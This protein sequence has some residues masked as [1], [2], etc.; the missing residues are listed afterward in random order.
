MVG[1]KKDTPSLGWAAKFERNRLVV[2]QASPYKADLIQQN[3]VVSR[4]R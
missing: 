3:D 1:A 2:M 4:T